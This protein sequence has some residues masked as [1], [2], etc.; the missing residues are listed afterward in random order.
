MQ[1]PD[2]IC[3]KCEGAMEVG[4]IIDHTYGAITQSSWVEGKPERSIWTGLKTSGKEQYNVQ[5]YRCQSCGYLES[6]AVGEAVKKSI[7]E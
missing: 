6:Y 4:I 3:T 7:F 5:T 2:F 1:A